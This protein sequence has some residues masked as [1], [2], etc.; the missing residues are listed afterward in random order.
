MPKPKRTRLQSV[1]VTP[2][3]KISS[4]WLV[5]S[6][7]ASY[8]PGQE[9]GGG[10]GN[11]LRGEGSLDGGGLDSGSSGGGGIVSSGVEDL[12]DVV[13]QRRHLCAMVRGSGRG[14]RAFERSGEST[15]AR[16]S[17]WFGAQE[18]VCKVQIE[19]S[20]Q[21][22]V[23]LAGGAAIVVLNGLGAA[24]EGYGPRSPLCARGSGT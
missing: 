15:R 20:S 22:H 24:D 13:D 9:L 3:R 18:T 14:A 11:G 16:R 8:F 5:F 1:P 10:D 23:G 17:T 7:L 21:V 6:A 12:L 19:I 4:L 2:L